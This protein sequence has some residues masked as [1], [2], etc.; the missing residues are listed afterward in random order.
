M[1]KILLIEDNKIMRE[2]TAELLQLTGYEVEVAVNGKEGIKKTK[3]FLP[4]LI[5]CDIMMPELDG[6]SVL[7]LLNKETE[8]ASIPFIFLT[9]K[10]EKSDMRQGMNMGADDFLT[11]PFQD[12]DLL[13]AVESRF[14]KLEILS[15]KYDVQSE[16]VHFFLKDVSKDLSLEYLSEK[17]DSQHYKPKEFLYREGEYGHYLYL[18]NEGQV[19]TYMLNEDGKEFITSIFGP[20][21]FFG[22]KSILEDRNYKEFAE[23]IKK[24]QISK[25]PKADFLSLIHKNIDIAEKFIKMMSKNLSHKED[26]L[27]QLA[28][29]SVRKR[30]ATKLKEII[31]DSAENYT[32]I[33]R[34]DLASMIGTA[35]ETLVR[36]LTEFKEEK[37]IDTEGSKITIVDMQKLNTLLKIW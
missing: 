12:I 24:C 7:H 36:T 37:I 8:T 26:E 5:I 25:I 3:T 35:K 1:K 29:S 33:S 23:T 27:L 22:Y 19:K 11:K 31:T 10:S 18:I 9:A 21:D 16:K 15:N 2:N 4:N 32:H 13:N 14:K 34:T 17:Y 20:G 28:Y 30:I 6:Y